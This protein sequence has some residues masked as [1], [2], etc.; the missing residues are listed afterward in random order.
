VALNTAC[1]IIRPDWPAPEQVQAAV[2]TRKGGSSTA[3]YAELNLAAHVGDDANAVRH[4]RALLSSSLSMPG[5][6]RWLNQVHSSRV[7]SAADIAGEVDADASVTEVVGT[8]CAVLTADCLPVLIADTRGRRVA[9][10]HAGWRGLCGGILANAVADFLQSGIAANDILVWLGPAIGAQKYE[11]DAPV[12]DAFADR[13]PECRDAF[14]ASRDGHWH[15][16]LYTVARISL[17]ALGVE[18]VYG[19]DFCTYSDE[20]FFSYRREATCGRQASLIW[21]KT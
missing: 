10:V 9:A 18:H 2:T 4:N 6:P 14:S 8:V 13:L 19:G 17:R 11:I 1:Q 20:R 3:G 15:L 5:E 16:N 12:R 7:V 21:L